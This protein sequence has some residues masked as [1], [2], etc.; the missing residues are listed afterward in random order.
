MKTEVSKKSYWSIV[1]IN[2]ILLLVFIWL[3][4]LD[5]FSTYLSIAENWIEI[6]PVVIFMLNFPLLFFIWKI[7]ILPGIVWCF[8]YESESRKIMLNMVF[9]NLIYL[10]VVWWNL[11]VVF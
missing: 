11:K 4:N 10:W 5:Y 6:N 8:V 9:V 3:N 1:K 2:F 7:I